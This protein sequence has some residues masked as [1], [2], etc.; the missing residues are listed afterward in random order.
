MAARAWPPHNSAVRWILAVP[1]LAVVLASAPA[2]ATEESGPRRFRGRAL[3]DV[4]A[5]LHAQGLTIVYSSALVGPEMVVEVEPKARE[6]RAIL[7]EVLRPLGLRAVDGEGGALLII[8]APPEPEA[9]APPQRPSPSVVL[10]EHVVVTP[11]HHQIVPQDVVATRVLDGG[12]VTMAPT[13]GS[14]PSKVVALLPGVASA[15][16]SA[17]FYARGSEAEDVS[18]VLDGLELYDPFHLSDLRSPFSFVDGRVIDSVEFVGGGFTAERGDRNGGFVEMTTAPPAEG[19]K[20][21]VEVGTLNSRLSYQTSTPAGPIVVSGRYWYPEA[22]G[23]PVPFGEDALRPTFADAYVKA[24]LYA[25][26]TSV[27]TAH[28]LLASD[29][30]TLS[31]IDGNERVDAGSKSGTVWFRFHRAWSPTVST[32]TVVSGGRFTRERDG[33]AD[34]NDAPI[35][36]NDHRSVQFYGFRT[37]ATWTA[38]ANAVVRGGVE[39]RT[40]GADLSYLRSG[41]DADTV[42]AVERYGVAFAAYATFR[43]ALGRRLTA[44]AG[45]RWDR[46][47]YAHARQWSPR[48]NLVWQPRPTDEV[49][50]GVGRFAQSLRI[51]ELRLSDGQTDYDPAEVSKQVDLAYRHRFAARWSLRIDAY[52]HELSQLHPR[53]EN[54]FQPVEIFPEVEAD[55][56]LIAPEGA[57]LK[58]IE[59]S[60]GALPGSALQWWASYSWSS[61]TDRIDGI[62][63][64]RSWD[65]THAVTGLVGYHWPRGWSLAF[66]GS[67]HTG[68]PTT[69]VS[70]QV[71]DEPDGTTSIEPALGPRNSAR[72]P[73]YAR[74]DV[75]VARMF[76]TAKGNISIELSVTN[77][78]D[79]D[80][81]CCVD[82]I[83]FR[84]EPDGAITTERDFGYWTGMTPSLQAVWSF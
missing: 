48:F 1:A 4:L 6:P 70:G 59:L 68:W 28:A 74:L 80:N 75:K 44:E 43:R 2:A 45:L 29:R 63:V 32:D 40:L 55:R 82:E 21:Q 38:G 47:T 42:L 9:A 37:D 12:D 13:L 72:L 18:L 83:R 33:I 15:D 56:V 7:E 67:V 79:R 22:V 71:V 62:S 41:S 60:F 27:L 30:A 34:P 76:A 65:Q 66:A 77:L 20:S 53:Y 16:G 81:A 61:A 50:L 49:R 64:P 24:G 19:S 57:T 26:A 35:V 5:E 25:S 69:P 8:R 52:L 3:V 36:V 39:A 73:T 17:T 14:D 84:T 11:S 58:G 46:Q 78:T 23:D 10:V 31:E 54:V 51:H